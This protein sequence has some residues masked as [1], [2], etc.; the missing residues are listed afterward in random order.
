MINKI[1]MLFRELVPW[2]EWLK[3]PL[4]P[5]EYF[6]SSLPYR[7]KGRW[8][9]VCEKESRKFGKIGY[10]TRENAR[11]IHCQSA[12][13][14]RFVWLYFQRMTDLFDGKQKK[15]L[16][17][18]P[19]T[20]FVSKLKESLRHGY[21]T[22]DLQNPRAMVRMDITDIQY[23]DDHF[24]II[25]CSHVLEHVQEDKKAM[26]EFCR[27]MKKDGW[28]IILVPITVENTFEDPSIV[29]PS[30]RLKVFGLKDHVRCYGPDY[31]DRLRESGFDVKVTYLSDMFGND[32][33]IRMG[34]SSASG[35]IYHCYKT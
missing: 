27:V 13:R 22:A 30:E 19:E 6:L 29:D 10:P 11:C 2:P 32:D 12:E 33:I 14:H 4:R 18:A 9:P 25:Y 7:G 24:D 17:V 20:C 16:H 23:P 8:C 5:V 15:M 35:V 31:A 3:K 1:V 21:I 28:A 26:R 34:L